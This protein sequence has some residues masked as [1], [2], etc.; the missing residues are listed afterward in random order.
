MPVLKNKPVEGHMVDLLLNCGHINVEAVE[1]AIYVPN[2][3]EKRTC[4]TCQKETTIKR[5][6]HPY[7]LDKKD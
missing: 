5:V 1:A 2:V 7:W 4:T 6:G 3:G